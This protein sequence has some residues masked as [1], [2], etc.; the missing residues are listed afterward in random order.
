MVFEAVWA[1]GMKW[2]SMPVMIRA[3]IPLV[4]L[5][6]I[7]GIPAIT[8]GTAYVGQVLFVMLLVLF[9]GT[10]VDAFTNRVQDDQ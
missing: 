2:A 5:V 7:L 6:L 1:D 4:L 8:S 9:M 3:S 10:L